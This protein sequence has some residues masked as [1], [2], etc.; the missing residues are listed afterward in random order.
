MAGEVSDDRRLVVDSDWVVVT[1]AARG[2][3]FEVA[4]RMGGKSP[5]LAIDV[6]SRELDIARAELTRRSGHAVELAVADVSDPAA[7]TAAIGRLPETA[8]VRCLV[9][10]AGIY[11]LCPA[12]VMPLSSFERVVSVNLTGAFIA[13]QLLFPR[14][15]RGSVIV[16]VSSING[17]RALPNR[18]SYASS[19][20]GLQMLT[21][22][23]AVEWAK[24]GVRAVSV[25][26]GIVD[27]LMNRRVEEELGVDTR[28]ARSR[29]PLGR[30]ASPQEISSV[31]EFVASPE[32]SY[33]TGTDILV[34]GAWSAYGA[35]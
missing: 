9:N 7:V 32:A 21:K 27:T 33:L 16:N 8:M 26:P 14:F 1:G 29:I 11:D 6:D 10:C 12:E 24:Y 17:H 34:D 30:I 3:G 4:N 18:V 25:S 28:S 23:L 31:V 35:P 2:I 13:C 22:C 19:K 15:G 20:A 5:V